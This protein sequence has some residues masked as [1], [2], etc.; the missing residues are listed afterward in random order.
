MRILSRLQSG[1]VTNAGALAEEC[2]VS[3]RQIFRDI[4]LLQDAGLSV[5]YDGRRQSYVAHQEQIPSSS[6][7][8]SEALSLLLIAMNLGHRT[9]LV[10]LM[11]PARDAALKLLR[12][13]PTSVQNAVGDLPKEVVIRSAGHLPAESVRGFFDELL[14]G[15]RQRV[16]VRIQCRLAVPGRTLTTLLSPYRLLFQGHAWYVIGRSSVHRDVRTFSVSRLTAVEL[17]KQ[18]YEIPPRFSLDTYLGDAWRLIR[19]PGKS[20]KVTV[21]FASSIA[22]SVADVVWHRTQ[23]TV[24]EDDGSLLMTVRVAGLSEIAWW[25]LGFGEQVEVVEP[26]QL[27]RE[28]ARRAEAA[29]SPYVAD[30]RG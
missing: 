24:W 22:G 30:A 17:T 18:S 7:S 12:T 27:R 20:Q 3:R 4:K 16:K 15:L 21:R 10:P 6:V 5:W 14:E 1:L 23:E 29:L 8:A 9:G 28:V 11:E 26:E 25:I 2:G 13:F 19:A